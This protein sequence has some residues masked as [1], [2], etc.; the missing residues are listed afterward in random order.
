[1]KKLWSYLLEPFKLILDSTL[2]YRLCKWVVSSSM[3]LI[4]VPVALLAILVSIFTNLFKEDISDSGNNESLFRLE[5]YYKL[6]EKQN[7]ISDDTLN[8][9]TIYVKENKTQYTHILV[10]DRTGSTNNQV[11]DSKS[12]LLYNHIKETFLPNIFIDE[13]EKQ[14][15]NKKLSIK[16]LLTLRFYQELRNEV[17]DNNNFNNVNKIAVVYFDGEQFTYPPLN[18]SYQYTKEY[19]FHP[20]EDKEVVRELIE[21]RIKDKLLLDGTHSSDF[22]ALF[23]EIQKLCSDNS[24]EKIILT[25]ISDFH[26][27][28]QD[29]NI[30]ESTIENFKENTSNISQ[31]NFI[32]CP[33]SN[34]QYR[35]KSDNL[36][37]LLEKHTRGFDNIITIDLGDYDN[38]NLE[39]DLIDIFDKKILGCFSPINF[40]GDRETIKFYYPKYNAQGLITAKSEIKIKNQGKD[41]SW[42]I[43]TPSS[44]KNE[45]NSFTI[46]YSVNDKN[47][48]KKTFTLNKHWHSLNARDSTIFIEMR[49]DPA[50]KIDEYKMEV[51]QNDGKN[52]IAYP[53]KLLEYMPKVISKYGNSLLN[54][55]CCIIIVFAFAGSL[56]LYK[57]KDEYFGN[58]KNKVFS[59]AL[60]AIL[61]I[62]ILLV[63]WSTK[64]LFLLITCITI[65]SIFLIIVVLCVIHKHGKS[66]LNNS[67]SLNTL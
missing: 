66:K 65:C 41:F 38:S 4:A 10:I 52:F 59:S 53:I 67:D 15:G 54:I 24:N 20:T 9:S 27:D 46:L 33:P 16:H 49:Y 25:I 7:Q 57:G 51:F 30:G 63:L 40:D 42:R 39:N 17:S 62:A 32:Y 58:L 6:F 26:H 37:S 50:I 43:A 55:L 56:L 45:N 60:I 21:S 11:L 64:Y 23:K 13:I 19:N 8:V 2:C 18:K 61:F 28:K 47:A 34:L 22:P 31:Y 35:V 29:I 44:Q 36:I 3:S 5:T 14:N 12:D 1:M 48:K